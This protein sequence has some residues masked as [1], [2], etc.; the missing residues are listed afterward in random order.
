MEEDYKSS[1][2]QPK[3]EEEAGIKQFQV[4]SDR[5]RYII[6]LLYLFQVVVCA[7]SNVPLTPIIHVVASTY[8]LETSM[9]SL[10]TSICQVGG[11]VFGIVSVKVG[12]AYGVKTTMLWGA[13]FLGVGM[14]LRAFMNIHYGFMLVGQ[15]FAGASTPFIAGVQNSVLIEWFNK[16]QRNIWVALASL[17][18]PIGAMLGFGMPFFF[19][20][21]NKDFDKEDQKKRIFRYLGTEAIISVSLTVLT[22]LLWRKST[23]ILEENSQG[24]HEDIRERDTYAFHDPTDK[25]VKDAWPQLKICLTRPSILSLF[26]VYWIGFGSMTMI[27]GQIA[28]ILECFGYP[29]TYGLVLSLVV[30]CCGVSGSILYSIFFI[31]KKQQFQSLYPASLLTAFCIFLMGL[32]CVKKQE[33]IFLILTGAFFGFFGLMISVIQ[34]EEMLRRIPQN[35][36]IAATLLNTS[37]CMLFAA[38]GIFLIG[39]LLEKNNPT[40]GTIIVM[41]LG[42]CFVTVFLLLFWASCSLESDTKKKKGLK[43]LAIEESLSRSRSGGSFSAKTAKSSITPD[44]IA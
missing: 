32:L 17:A 11:L 36:M 1:G 22:L 24:S 44:L 31:K 35:L 12:T 21:N 26:L 2:S 43:K 42:T 8:D 10:S 6:I 23:A 20:D 37:G 28:G 18:P 3:T 30:I 19:I 29:N 7:M 9:V 41:G 38:I 13:L 14:G 25:A 40:N 27:G 33:L 4:G 15:I 5:Y 34:I 16:E 39:L